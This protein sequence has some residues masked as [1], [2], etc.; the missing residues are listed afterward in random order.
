MPGFLC[1]TCK[2]SDTLYKSG[3]VQRIGFFILFLILR[4]DTG[5][6]SS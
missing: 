5:G 3:N 4:T 1:P 2:D 6:A